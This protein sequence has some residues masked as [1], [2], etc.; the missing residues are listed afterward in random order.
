MTK[1]QKML[2]GVGAVAVVGYLVYKQM[3]KSKGFASMAPQPVFAKATGGMS[4]LAPSFSLA[5]PCTGAN[6][7]GGA[8]A[9]TA[10]GMC[11]HG[12][13]SGKACKCCKTGKYAE[14]TFNSGCAKATTVASRMGAA[15]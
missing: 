10:S 8:D 11:C 2:L 13:C 12:E 14:G 6:G 4:R 1:N 5:Q 15:Y 9:S 7:G 3:N